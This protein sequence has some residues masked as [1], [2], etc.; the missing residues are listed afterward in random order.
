MEEATE[1]FKT[2]SSSS[3]CFLSNHT[4]LAK[5]KTGTTN[6]SLKV[7]CSCVVD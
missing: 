1:K 4:L 5:P 7:F 2:I 3:N 6:P